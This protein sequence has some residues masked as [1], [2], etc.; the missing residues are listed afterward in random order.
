MTEKYKL[1]LLNAIAKHSKVNH[2]YIQ[3]FLNQNGYVSKKILPAFIA[4]PIG[5]INGIKCIL[6]F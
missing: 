6:Q 4:A 2:S 1:A 5:K 3:A